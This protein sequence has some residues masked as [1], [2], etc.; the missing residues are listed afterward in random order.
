MNANKQM[1]KAVRYHVVTVLR[2]VEIPG[3]VAIE[4]IL[5]LGKWQEVS[6]SGSRDPRPTLEF[7]NQ[8]QRGRFL[9]SSDR[10]KTTTRGV[11][12]AEPDD[13]AIGK[14]KFEDA[15]GWLPGFNT[16]GLQVPK[17]RIQGLYEGGQL[18]ATPR[19]RAAGAH[20][21]TRSG[22]NTRD[23]HKPEETKHGCFQS[24]SEVGAPEY[25]KTT[26]KGPWSN[27]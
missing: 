16:S 4:R 27:S 26:G 24:G 6:D 13:S 15:M 18:H 7:A 5:R 23:C 25:H 10:T 12:K 22:S 11:F 17:L 21:A 14:I 9:A 19:S 1:E 8:R 2:M 20:R 3:F